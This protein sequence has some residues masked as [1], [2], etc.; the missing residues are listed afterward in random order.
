MI[1]E[2]Q[3]IQEKKILIWGAR[4][5]ALMVAD[6]FRSGGT[7]HIAYFLDDTL[8]ARTEKH[9][10]GVPLLT[11][12]AVLAR[13]LKSG[14][15][16]AL[17]AIGDCAARM[18]LASEALR[19]GFE[20]ATAIHPRAIVSSDAKL[21]KGTVVAPGAVVNTY[22]CVGD[23]VILNTSC[24]VDHECVIEDGVHIGPGVH[25][26]GKVRVGQGA[27]IGIG[28][29]VGDKLHIGAGSIIGA[30]AVVL[31]DIPPGVL[32]YGVPARIMRKLGDKHHDTTV[33]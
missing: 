25:L 22:S 7:Y 13:L 30:G 12:R 2:S 3:R 18:H 26:G 1:R 23:N 17:I 29:V 10:C 20:L 4:G 31:R 9:Y 8:P 11:D 14:I 16:H 15:K 28:A 32:A 27:W 19:L 21:G 6:V 5:H 33:K 24:S